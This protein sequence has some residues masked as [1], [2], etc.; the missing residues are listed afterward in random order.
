VNTDFPMLGGN[1]NVCFGSESRP[2][3]VVQ[4]YRGLGVRFRPE[5]VIRASDKMPI[6]S[7]SRF[8]VKSSSLP[9]N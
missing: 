3:A 8:I 6:D 5:A 4:Q 9:I 7:T 1:R 2:F